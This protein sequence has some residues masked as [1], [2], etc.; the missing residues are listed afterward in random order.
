MKTKVKTILVLS[1]LVLLHSAVAAQ[2]RTEKTETVEDLRLQLIELQSK[3]DMLR[4]RAQQFAEDLSGPSFAR[5]EE[6]EPGSY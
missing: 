5:E 4:I 3:E 6:H 2:E 1:L